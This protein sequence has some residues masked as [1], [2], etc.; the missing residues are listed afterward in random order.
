MT[1]ATNYDSAVKMLVDA[2]TISPMY[3]IVGGM[4]PREGVVIVRDRWG[5]VNMTKMDDTTH[6]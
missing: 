4:K 3:F 2:D 6:K 5:A 1:H